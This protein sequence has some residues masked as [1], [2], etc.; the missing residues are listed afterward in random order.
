MLARG[1]VQGPG[2]HLATRSPG[3]G[4]DRVRTSADRR[5][6]GT[7]CWR[8][9]PR[10]ART[11]RRARSSRRRRRT[12]SRTP[13]PTR[14][15]TTRA[16]AARTT[17]TS[18]LVPAHDGRE[19]QRGRARQEPVDVP[20][21]HRTSSHSTASRKPPATQAPLTSATVDRAGSVVL[22]RWHRA[23]HER[24]P[25]RRAHPRR[26]RLRQAGHLRVVHRGHVEDVGRAPTGPRRARRPPRRRG[27][28][29]RGS[30]PSATTTACSGSPGSAFRR[31]ATFWATRP[32]PAIAT[33]TRCGWALARDVVPGEQAALHEQDRARGAPT[34][35]ARRVGSRHRPGRDRAGR[36]RTDAPGASA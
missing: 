26:H 17:A 36:S 29:A 9:P 11:A 1:A 28:S 3:A 35:S 23:R 34:S 31:C 5:G 25:H 8:G 18:R 14:R 16:A 7:A 33:G 19:H 30:S 21:R 20:R 2:R 13:A 27:R 24:A 15:R 32:A 12:C 10:P 4:A 22:A 6:R